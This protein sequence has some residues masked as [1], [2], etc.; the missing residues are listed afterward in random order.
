MR[1]LEFVAILKLLSTTLSH[2]PKWLLELITYQDNILK[3]IHDPGAVGARSG[4]LGGG[5]RGRGRRR[6][7]GSGSSSG[8]SNSGRGGILTPRG[9]VLRDFNNPESHPSSDYQPRDHQ[10]HLNEEGAWHGTC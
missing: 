4:I 2:T 9:R 7:P 1:Y 3:S 8:R 6:G 10:P 5:G